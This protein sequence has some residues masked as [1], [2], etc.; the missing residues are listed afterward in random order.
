MRR[1][2]GF[3]LP[4]GLAA[5]SAGCGGGAI[6]PEWSESDADHAGYILAVE[7]ADPATQWPDRIVLGP[8]P[9]DPPVERR[10]IYY[11]SA[12]TEIYRRR[13]GSLRPG[14]FADLVAGARIYAWTGGTEL[15]SMPP[16]YGATRI[17][18]WE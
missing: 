8:Y 15:R 2:P 6:E 10:A 13:N 18:V 5:F 14:S 17:V 1:F 16:Q 9:G 7:D 12:D 4:V 11:V 3:V